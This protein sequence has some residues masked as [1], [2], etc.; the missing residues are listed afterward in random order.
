MINT[1]ITSIKELDEFS[2][3]AYNKKQGTGLTNKKTL[4]VK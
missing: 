1:L 2:S 3:W 4:L